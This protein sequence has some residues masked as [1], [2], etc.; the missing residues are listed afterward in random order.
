HTTSFH[1]RFGALHLLLFLLMIRRPPR[2]TL[3]PYTTLFRSGAGMA[4]GY[5]FRNQCFKNASSGFVHAFRFHPLRIRLLGNPFGFTFGILFK[6][7]FSKKVLLAHMP[8]VPT[9]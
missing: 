8:A 6:R 5:L 4:S 1:Y 9:L 7:V 2:S 3:F